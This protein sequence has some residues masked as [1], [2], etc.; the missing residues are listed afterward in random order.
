ML[1]T[2]LLSLSFFSLQFAVAS[3]KDMGLPE[4]PAHGQLLRMAAN[5]DIV[6]ARP[7]MNIRKDASDQRYWLEVQ[8]ADKKARTA[9]AS[10]GMSF[11][12]I[13]EASVQGIA[14]GQTLKQL[15]E[16]GFKILQ[17]ES[18]ETFDK[19]FSREFPPEDAAYH[20]YAETYAALKVMAD[21]NPKL[22]SL[23]SIG[24]SAEGRDI[25]AVRF[26]D[27]QKANEPSKKP[28]VVFIGNHHA[29][30]HL[31]VEVPLAYAQWL[32]DNRD[33][34]GVRQLLR[35]RDIFVIPMVNPDGAEYDVATGKYRW[36]RKNTRKLEASIGVDLNRNYGYLW[37]GPGASP[38]PNA[39]TYRGPSAF[40]EPE[41]KAVRKFFDDHTNMKVMISYHSYGQMV[42]YP[43]G[44]TDSVIE[45]E[46]DFAAHKTIAGKIAEFT[47]YRP[48]Q[49]S[50]L[51]VATGDTCDWTYAEHKVFSFT[52]ELDPQQWG[53]GGFYPGADMIGISVPRNIKAAHYVTA[54]ADNPYQTIE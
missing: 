21:K 20:S 45:N 9:L 16:Q 23:F 47:D 8:A 44:G 39:E 11:E 6:P 51:Y 14:S 52:I 34:A 42:M 24:K 22:V 28:G 25:W 46:K 29:R 50:D 10:A 15:H 5:P 1:K 13:G 7:S 2:I 18:L 37:G 41:T 49:S 31:S 30:E 54:I 12:D 48:M 19:L 3:D 35:E 36:W 40:S 33:D 53:Y 43:W 26:N 27:T 32:S 17:S 38:N 4:N